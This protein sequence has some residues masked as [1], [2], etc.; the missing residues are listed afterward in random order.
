MSWNI[1]G[2]SR[3][4]FNL[5]HFTDLYQ[6]DLV[7]LSEPQIYSCDLAQTMKY[8]SGA[9][10]SSLNSADIYDPELPL[11]KSKANGGTMVLWKRR[12]DPHIK[13]YP[14]Q[15]PAF[16]PVIFQ[17][18]GSA[19][20][21]HIAVYLPTLGRESEFIE[22]LS[23]LSI[24]VDELSETH[25]D[26]PI[27]L[28]GDF[29]VSKTNAKRTQLLDHFCSQHNL[30]QTLITKPTYHHFVGDGKSDSFLDRILFSGSA[31]HQEVLRTI[32]CCLTNP[33]LKSHHD[34][35]VSEFFIP[36]EEIED[37]T[38]DNIVAPTIPNSRVKVIWSDDGIEEYQA[39]VIPQ[40][41]RIQE[42]W[43]SSPSRTTVSLLL[44]STNNV[45]ISCA[46]VTNRTIRLN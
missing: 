22:E 28:R 37:S 24:T 13:L 3:N 14:V 34:L 17:P 12:H 16:L 4:V 7:F 5:K 36:D 11:V 39:L 26:A 31:A 8:L 20:S 25:P 10:A 45:L 38:D 15:T 46:A 21:I 44:E 9:Y 33:L 1:E 19:P 27:Y 30:L 23:K 40:L 41:A 29:N 35:L 18:P 43:L 2:L 6:P 32:E 42:Q